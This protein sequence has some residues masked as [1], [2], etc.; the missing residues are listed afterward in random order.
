MN[1]KVTKS[2]Q[3]QIVGIVRG[4]RRCIAIVEPCRKYGI[5]TRH[6]MLGKHL[7]VPN[8]S[9]SFAVT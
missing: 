1:N 7:T 4:I 2:R 9:L 6:Q 3:E 5:Q 8:K